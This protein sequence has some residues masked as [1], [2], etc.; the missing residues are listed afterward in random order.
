WW[1]DDLNGDG[2]YEWVV[3]VKVPGLEASLPWGA[4]AKVWVADSVA[5]R[6]VYEA[7]S[8]TF[9]ALEVLALQDL[10]GDGLS[11]VL[12][13]IRNCGAHTCY[14]AYYLLS[15]HQSDAPRLLH[16]SLANQDQDQDQDQ[17]QEQDQEQDQD[18]DQDQADNTSP[19]A[20]M[21]SSEWA[22][23]DWT[24]DGLPD[25]VLSGGM[26]GSATLGLQRARTEVY[27]W[28]GE[29]MSLAEVRYQ[30]SDLRYFKL[31]DGNNAFA[32]GDYNLALLLYDEAATSSELKES[33]WR[34]KES[35]ASEP[36]AIQQYAGF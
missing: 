11:E 25:L 6:V 19:L 2:H 13:E 1:W 17:D 5:Q 28:D 33:Q 4:P 23:E 15:Y 12:Y 31:L 7:A 30:P 22:V 32:S 26:I 29:L 34:I 36:F 10:T 24:G 9:G 20:N 8:E 21:P 27:A 35:D 16:F 3:Q 18:Q 14:Q